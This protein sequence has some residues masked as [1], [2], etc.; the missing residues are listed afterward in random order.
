[1]TKEAEAA[2]AAKKAKEASES[3]MNSGT[4][5]GVGGLVIALLLWY[6]RSLKPMFA[7]GVAVLALGAGWY[8]QPE[9]PEDKKAGA[10]S[11][12]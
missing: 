10:T 5:I 3:W 1:M 6:T 11:D 2:A 4:Y 9:K 8:M 12:A 7:L